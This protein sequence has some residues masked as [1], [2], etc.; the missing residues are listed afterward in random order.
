MATSLA[1]QPVREVISAP[2]QHFQTAASG[3]RELL[4]CSKRGRKA[5]IQCS[6]TYCEY[7]SF[8]RKNAAPE[9]ISLVRALP[10]NSSM[11]RTSLNYRFLVSVAPAGPR[12]VRFSAN[13]GARGQ[14]CPLMRCTTREEPLPSVY[15]TNLQCLRPPKSPRAPLKGPEGLCSLV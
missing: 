8:L 11:L 3:P 9:C 10:S 13:G 1:E 5:W 2:Q 15:S 14:K 12:G 6:A 7:N 4:R